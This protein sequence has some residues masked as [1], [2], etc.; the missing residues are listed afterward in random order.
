MHDW[1]P[2]TKLLMV[3]FLDLAGRWFFLVFFLRVEAADTE[4]SSKDI[5]LKWAIAVEG[6]AY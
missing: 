3:Y 2:V 5:G 1:F 4:D 6:Y